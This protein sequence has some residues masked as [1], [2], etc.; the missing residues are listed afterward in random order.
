MKKNAM[1][2][3]GT[4]VL[5]LWAEFSFSQNS[6]LSEGDWYKVSVSDYGIYKIGYDDLLS[7]GIDPGQVN[8]KNLRLYGNGN[9]MLPEAND[10]FRYDDLQ[11]IA[12]FVYGEE[13][14]VFDPGDYILFYGE[15]PTEW[16]YNEETGHFEHETN[17]YTDEV[18]YFL[19]FDTG[20]GKRIENQYSTIIPHNNTVNTFDDYF[21]HELELENLIHSGKQ[22]YGEKFDGTIVYSWI[23]NFPNLLI[24]YPVF[25]YTSGAARSSASSMFTFSAG[26]SNLELNFYGVNMT[27]QNGDYAKD[28]FDTIS[29]Y[30][31][32]PIIDLEIFYNKPNDSSVAWLDYFGLNFKRSLTHTET[33]MRF[34]NLESIGSGKIGRFEISSASEDMVVW[35]IT[36]PLNPALI[37]YDLISGVANFTL[38][39]DS[40]LEFISF[41]DNG[42]LEIDLLEPINN[43]NLHGLSSVDLIIVSAEEFLTQANDLAEFR[44]LNDG[45]NVLVTTPKIVYNEFSSGVQDVTAI[46]DFVKYLINNSSIN[47]SKYLLLIG[48]G[49]YDY[50][51]RV[52]NNTNFIPVWES[53]VSLNPVASYCTDDFFGITESASNPTI[54]ISIGRL[55]VTNL[56]EADAIVQKIIL[57]SSSLEKM[58]NWRN[59]V[60]FIADDEDSNLHFT[61]VEELCGMVDAINRPWNIKKIYVDAYPQDTLENGQQICPDVNMAITEKINQGVLL[62]NYTG[63]GNHEALSYEKILTSEDIQNWTNSNR[64]PVMI[65]ATGALSRFDDPEIISLSEKCVLPSEKG[66][67]AVFAPAR[68]TYAGANYQFHTQLLNAIN[69]NPGLTFGMQIKLAKNMGGNNANNL[70]FIL[71]GDPSM[72]LAIPLL[73]IT[74]T[75]V[76]GIDASIFQDTLQPGEQI[77]ISGQLTDSLNNQ[78]YDFSGILKIKVFERAIVDSTLGNDP[79]SAVSTFLRQDSV[80]LDLETEVLNGQFAATFN[81]PQSMNEEYGYI[82]LSYYASEELKDARGQYSGIMVGGQTSSTSEY[83]MKKFI[84]LYPTITSG[85]LNFSLKE[86]VPQ[87]H[88]DIVNLSGNKVFEKEYSRYK[89]GERGQIN[90]S[91]LEKGFYIVRIYFENKVNFFKVIKQ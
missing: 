5:L 68:A 27:N 13:D 71:F 26:N 82:K 19:N 62:L 15:G 31:D 65:N 17:I 6:V 18:C 3:V 32:D 67:I 50:K 64:F 48:K 45:L 88:I 30:V 24:E 75:A 63:H 41:T 58:G 61:D 72:R 28:K 12:I 66:M 53:E 90:L 76:N 86:E 42:F 84:E 1:F 81:L 89:S 91:S 52:D 55:P 83:S 7:F 60:C 69:N 73:N 78:V 4:I 85:I 22:W 39:T 54:E 46:R 43:Q 25:L 33:Q 36:D 87:L 37:E 11:E 2:F 56:S 51:D 35:N 29:F 20:P 38:E 79:N 49:S 70:K 14:E 9:G 57:Y 8:P 16:N 10:E 47:P 77:N 23:L 21:A 34:R 74:T 40:L 44:E 59:E 80:L